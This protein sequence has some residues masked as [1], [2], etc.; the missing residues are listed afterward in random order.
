MRKNAK[1]LASL[2]ATSAL[3]GNIDSIKICKRLSFQCPW[4]F[5]KKKSG[6]YI[7]FLLTCAIHLKVS[8]I[9]GYNFRIVNL[10][11]ENR[12]KCRMAYLHKLHSFLYGPPAEF[13]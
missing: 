9:L 13:E 6:K 11:G 8:C 1:Y 4:L 7:L 10:F 2:F 12:E 5:A 3:M